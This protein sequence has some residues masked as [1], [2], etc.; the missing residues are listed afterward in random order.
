MCQL[1][2]PQALRR[3]SART[4]KFARKIIGRTVP[5]DDMR[6]W[7]AASGGFCNE[8]LAAVVRMG[9]ADGDRAGRPYAQ[10]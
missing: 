5:E 6:G 3:F 1:S 8:F 10:L 9:A 2:T 7:P 4:K